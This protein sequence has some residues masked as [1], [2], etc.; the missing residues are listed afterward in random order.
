MKK[1]IV[2]IIILIFKTNTTLSNSLTIIDSN[3]KD[4]YR[5]VS[6]DG[7]TTEILFSLGLGKYIVGRDISSYYPKEANNISSVGY[8]Y[9]LSSEGILS[10]KPTLILGQ[11]DVRPKTV[12]DQIKSTGINVVLSNDIDSCLDT[13]SYINYLGEMFN[14]KNNSDKLVE[15]LKSK[16]KK[17][18]LLNDENKKLIKVLMLYIRGYKLKLVLGRNSG[19]SKMLKYVN[20]LNVGNHINETKPVTAESMVNM[21]P[22][23]I[24]LFKK[25]V[26]SIGG[27][28]GMVN[29]EGVS[30]TNAGRN[31]RFVIMD[32][33]YLGGFG[34][35]CGDAALDLYYGINQKKGIFQ[36][37]G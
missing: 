36:S 6:L 7:T 16:L 28:K 9:R 22:D 17:I 23:V 37:D 13:I 31:E 34:P 24:V 29:I 33:L 32:D 2:F 4:S 3:L 15:N 8:K 10:L 25:G 19:P 14:K 11:N 1:Y 5:I 30:Y 26:E 20:A 35:R 12:I 21:N 18:K 27:I